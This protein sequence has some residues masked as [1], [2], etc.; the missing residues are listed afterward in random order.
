MTQANKHY[1]TAYYLR[2]ARKN[3][4]A[5]HELVKAGTMLTVVELDLLMD[6]HIQLGHFRDTMI[7]E[8]LNAGKSGKHVAMLFGLTEGRISQI[9]KHYQQFRNTEQQPNQQ[10]EEVNDH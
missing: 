3:I 4:D 10:K 6:L 1:T 7:V 2:Q 9:K 8:H 5:A